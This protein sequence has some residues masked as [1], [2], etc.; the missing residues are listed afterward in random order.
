MQ[1]KTEAIVLKCV[2]YADRK[3][4]VEMF[5]ADY[6]HLAFAVTVSA[7]GRGKMK[8]Q[9]FMPLSILDIAFDLRANHPLQRISDI[10]LVYPMPQLYDDAVKLPVAMFVTELLAVATRNEQTNSLLYLYIKQGVEWLSV[11]AEGIA[12]FHLIFMAKLARFLGFSPDDRT[13]AD[14][15]W[16]DLREGCFTCVR[17]MHHD[18]AN[19]D[20]TR[21]IVA[22]VRCDSFSLTN[23][24]LSR[25]DRNACLDAL[26]DYYRLHLPAFPELKSITVLRQVF[27]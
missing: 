25:T 6:G 12:D 23:L 26:V 22:L 8:K 21:N 15:S 13:Y 17:P 10:R 18:V 20:L 1:V 7:S 4:V 5:T 11:A 2:S 3:M 16:F 24:R 27:E 19:P 14:G 9:Y